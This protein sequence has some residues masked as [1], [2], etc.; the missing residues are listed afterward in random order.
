[1]NSLTHTNHS[2]VNEKYYQKK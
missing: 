1:M 2:Y